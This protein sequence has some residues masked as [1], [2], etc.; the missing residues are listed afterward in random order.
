MQFFIVSLHIHQ[1]QKNIC[2]IY[3]QMNMMIQTKK[4]FPISVQTSLA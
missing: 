3:D 4:N 2:G 1:K